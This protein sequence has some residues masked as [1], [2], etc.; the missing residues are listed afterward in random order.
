MGVALDA[1]FPPEKI[2][3]VTGI[4]SSCYS[5]DQKLILQPISSFIPPDPVLE[6]EEYQKTGVDDDG[7]DFVKDRMGE[8]AAA[9]DKPCADDPNKD[10][11][12]TSEEVT[13]EN[14]I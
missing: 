11:E 9:I 5:L 7:S 2:Q 10:V 14:V 12:L 4:K 6:I 13:E 8:I 3:L 1:V